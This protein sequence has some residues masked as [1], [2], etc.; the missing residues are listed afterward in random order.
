MRMSKK[1]RKRKKKLQ[2]YNKRL[3]KKYYWLV[4]R[5]V[6]T[7]KIPKDYD[8]TYIDW[9]WNDGW[10][11]AFGMMYMKEL[12]EEIKR[13]GQKNFSI[14]QIKEK[15]GGARLYSNGCSEKAHSIIDK[16][17]TISQ[18]ICIVC[19]VEAPMIDDG[20]M[21]PYCFNCWK[22]LYRRREQYY[23]EHAPKTDDEIRE[24]Y[25]KFIKDE[26]TE[27]GKWLRDTYT[28]RR[29]SMDGHEDITVDIS[30]TVEKLRRRRAK[31]ITH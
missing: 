6:W 21:S 31:W 17:E 12:G 15:F 16:Y 10:D 4:P 22:K 30:D 7:G 20:W 19:G 24:I 29:Y 13:S 11:K 5:D 26:P 25:E 2:M 14:L 8:Y 28:I 3:I 18:N 9:G 27:D 23:P 1:Q